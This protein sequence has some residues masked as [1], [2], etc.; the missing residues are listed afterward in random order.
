[1]DFLKIDDGPSEP[2]PPIPAP[3]PRV[4]K[5]QAR[6]E[7]LQISPNALKQVND[8]VPST[9]SSLNRPVSRQNA[10][11][12]AQS[13]I[14]PTAR[15]AKDP[16][17]PAAFAQFQRESEIEDDEDEVPRA[18]FSLQ[19]FLQE[20]KQKEND[21][22]IDKLLANV[23]EPIDIPSSPL[24]Q[25][26]SAKSKRPRVKKLGMR[27]ISFGQHKNEKPD[28]QGN[29]QNQKYEPKAIAKV[30][31]K[32]PHDDT[33]PATRVT[34]D[35]HFSIDELFEGDDE[36][37][38]TVG[39][40]DS[41]GEQQLSVFDFL[42][43]EAHA[44][45]PRP[46]SPTLPG[47]GRLAVVKKEHCRN[48][49]V[50]LQEEDDVF[51]IQSTSFG[52]KRE[53]KKGPLAYRPPAPL[54]L[55]LKYNPNILPSLPTQLVIED[56]FLTSTVAALCSVSSTNA[57]RAMS[58][59]SKT[60]PR[61]RTGTPLGLQRATS[62][63]SKSTKRHS[64]TSSSSIVLFDR[65]NRQS[66]ASLSGLKRHSLTSIIEA[67]RHSLTSIADLKRLSLTSITDAS[68]RLS[69]PKLEEIK[70]HPAET[71]ADGSS[72]LPVPSITDKR[73]SVATVSTSSTEALSLSQ[74]FGRSLKI[75]KLRSWSK[76]VP[77]SPRSPGSPRLFS[78]RSRVFTPK[79]PAVTSDEGLSD[80]FKAMIKN[81]IA[82]R[83]ATV[84]PILLQKHLDD[85]EFARAVKAQ[86]KEDESS[87]LA[88]EKQRARNDAVTVLSDWHDH[89]KIASILDRDG[90][91]DRL[92]SACKAL[93]SKVIGKPGRSP[94]SCP[95]PP[96][97]TSTFPTIMGL[98]SS[99]A[100][101]NEIESTLSIN[102]PGSSWSS[103]FTSR[104]MSEATSRAETPTSPTFNSRTASTTART[105]GS[106]TPSSPSLIS[107]STSSITFPL[108]SSIATIDR[109]DSPSGYS[110]SSQLT[111]RRPSA[112][113]TVTSLN[114]FGPFVHWDR[115]I[116]TRE[117]VKEREKLDL[118]QQ[119]RNQEAVMRGEKLTSKDL[120]LN[121]KFKGLERYMA[122]DMAQRD[123]RKAYSNREDAK[124]TA[125]EVARGYLDAFDP[126]YTSELA[127]VYPNGPS[128]TYSYGTWSD[129]D[130][131]G[132]EGIQHFKVLWTLRFL[133]RCE[134][135]GW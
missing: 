64:D 22:L 39:G 48:T 134:E 106:E 28:L 26:E 61:R 19:E 101:D 46:D 25:K 93:T 125:A 13:V 24:S 45:C 123:L 47:E 44:H 119:L 118:E 55:P 110:F 5:L 62:T 89:V 60:A 40:L 37:P 120:V 9:P 41:P 73:V 65:P 102:T 7:K 95:A 94:L 84:R 29:T 98:V 76:L 131:V 11:E 129:L 53:E 132:E 107:R 96:C 23:L 130:M 18:G 111:S 80:E 35:V 77:G 30:T 70:R 16:G 100:R 91:E 1:M 90:K 50:G 83:L 66:I 49:S 58:V 42:E 32:N 4:K 56:D 109:P 6:S 20:D 116:E 34:S 2:I 43:Q 52:S 27:L 114:P 67:K 72:R 112:A 63:A 97:F 74:S 71:M 126:N 69:I 51:K 36:Q 3:S 78:P 75:R 33:H 79:N 115:P 121:G 59:L 135:N 21:E 38:H 8:R 124:V 12:R 133:E 103:F 122:H 92:D 87:S 117:E 86:K 81:K 17:T 88:E 15:L 68:K 104:K 82:E 31:P 10:W 14:S 108:L 127:L 57:T 113:G 128:D 85:V 105:S 54:R 99:L